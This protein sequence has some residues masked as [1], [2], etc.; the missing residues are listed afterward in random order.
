MRMHN[1]GTFNNT[2]ILDC[3][4]GESGQ[5]NTPYLFVI[6]KTTDAEITG[7]FY[8]T[9]KSAAF[10][11]EKLLAMGVPKDM[12]WGAVC[13]AIEGGSL[14][15]GNCVQITVERESYEGKDRAV[16]KSVRPNNFVGG[17][18]RSETGA[19][20]AKKF[21]AIWRKTAKAAPSTNTP[22]PVTPDEEDDVPF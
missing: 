2:E 13:E 6:F 9:E 19:A 4:F 5:N 22:A 10:T 14:L 20:N 12:D 16:I 8:L 18:T 15:V 21:G 11:Q 1:P 3:G 7:Y 17:P